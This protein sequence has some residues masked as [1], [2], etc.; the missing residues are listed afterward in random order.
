MVQ[1]EDGDPSKLYR[2]K[3]DSKNYIYKDSPFNESPGSPN[4]P[5]QPAE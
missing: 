4:P 1:K 2:N 3:H 5:G